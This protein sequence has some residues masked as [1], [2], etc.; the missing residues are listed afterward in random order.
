MLILFKRQIRVRVAVETASGNFR[1]RYVTVDGVPGDREA[2]LNSKASTEYRRIH[3]IRNRI[4]AVE[5][6]R[7]Q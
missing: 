2:D 4:V 3:G 6:C 7:G 5:V 1:N